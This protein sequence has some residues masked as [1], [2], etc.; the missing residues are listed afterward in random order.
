VVIIVT[1]CDHCTVRARQEDAS[2]AFSHR[3]S[4]RRGFYILYASSREALP[5]GGHPYDYLVVALVVARVAT[6]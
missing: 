2:V 5:M 1:V 6:R 3:T 4:E